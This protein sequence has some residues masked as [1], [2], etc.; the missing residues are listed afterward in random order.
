[1]LKNILK[2]NL[3]NKMERAIAAI[4]EDESGHEVMVHIRE[5]DFHGDDIKFHIA[6]GNKIDQFDVSSPYP[7]ELDE[8]EEI[9]KATDDN[10]TDNTKKGSPDSVKSGIVNLI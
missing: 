6:F 2:N 9:N 8:D 5:V 4:L 7:E 1:M 3:T 10:T